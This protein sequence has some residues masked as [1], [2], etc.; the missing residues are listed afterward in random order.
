MEPC[1]IVQF[2][3][4]QKLI[5]QDCTISYFI[6]ESNNCRKPYCFNLRVVSTYQKKL[7]SIC[8]ICSACYLVDNQGVAGGA[9]NFLS[10]PIC[11]SSKWLIYKMLRSGADGA[12]VLQTFPVIVNKW[13][14]SAATGTSRL[15]LSH[16]APTAVSCSADGCFTPRFRIYHKAIYPRLGHDLG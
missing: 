9:D 14:S 1:G 8:S 3:R 2:I 16:A 15:R 13:F 11:S 4:K 10:A 12:D 7:Q 6:R 5:K